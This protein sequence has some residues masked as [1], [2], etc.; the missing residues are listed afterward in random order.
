MDLQDYQTEFQNFTFCDSVKHQI[1]HIILF[2]FSKYYNDDDV[3]DSFLLSKEWKTWKS[4][5][6]SRHFLRTILGTIFKA[7]S[8]KHNMA[9]AFTAHL[10]CVAK[11]RPRPT[12]LMAGHPLPWLLPHKASFEST[13]KWFVFNYYAPQIFW[14]TIIVQGIMEAKGSNPMVF[15]GDRS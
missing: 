3:L 5:H 15:G 1:S 11:F 6:V 2:W 12:W 9:Q 4:G 13:C 14:G 7:Q 8:S 10:Q